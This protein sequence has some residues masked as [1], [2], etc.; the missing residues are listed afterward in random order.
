MRKT[1]LLFGLLMG[2]AWLPHAQAQSGPTNIV[3]A[4]Y[5]GPLGG[6][7]ATGPARIVPVGTVCSTGEVAVTWNITGPQGPIGPQGT[8]GPAGPTGATGPAGA[9]GPVGLTGPVGPAGAMGPAG[10]NG[11]AGA[12][13]AVG[14][15]GPAGPM[16][17]AG[18]NGPAGPT[19]PAGPAG[20]TGPAGAT[21]PAGPQGPAGVGLQ[22]ATGPVGPAGPQG[23]TGATGPAGPSGTA[24]L[25][26]TDTSHAAA[27]RNECLMGTVALSAGAVALHTLAAGQI[28]AISSNTAL[29]SLLGTTYG[30]NGQTNFALPDLRAAAPNGLTY[31]I[32]TQ[33]IYPVRL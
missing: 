15:A 6:R 3:Q 19:G 14:P 24:A 31:W 4:C 28:L 7:P 9:T 30:G 1:T 18:A 2:F 25:F 26:G 16:G 12:A 22:G 17:P 5:P 29:F 32:C 27:G 11:P 10:A 13:G 21:G 23:A 33:G 8:T 20:P